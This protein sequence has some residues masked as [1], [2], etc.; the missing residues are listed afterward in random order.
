MDGQ[1]TWIIHSKLKTP[2][3]FYD[4]F[5]LKKITGKTFNKIGDRLKNKLQLTMG[6]FLKHSM[7]E[8]LAVP[9]SSNCSQYCAHAQ[10]DVTLSRIKTCS[11][12]IIQGISF[13]IRCAEDLTSRFEARVPATNQ[14]QSWASKA[15]RQILRSV[16][17]VPG[18]LLPHLAIKKSHITN[19]NRLWKNSNNWLCFVDNS[20]K[21]Q[22]Y[23]WKVQ[24]ACIIWN[25]VRF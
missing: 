12:R 5:N 1:T 10:D 15:R 20:C 19:H 3:G 2:F 8:D 18:S 25:N 11:W 14:G 16:S 22:K 17:C 21:P 6:D 13:D 4:L 9:H 24:P 23:T 7:A